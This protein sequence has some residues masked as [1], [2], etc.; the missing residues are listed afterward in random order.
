MNAPRRRRAQVR[1]QLE[2]AGRSAGIDSIGTAWN[3]LPAWA[4]GLAPIVVA[5]A[6][7]GL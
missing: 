1:A 4:R 7:A 6:L 2:G 5:V 3:Q